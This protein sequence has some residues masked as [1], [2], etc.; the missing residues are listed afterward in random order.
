MKLEILFDDRDKLAIDR[1][2]ILNTWS[3]YITEQFKT[4]RPDDIELISLE[5]SPE[6]ITL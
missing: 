3:S 5:E 4:P 1:E 6:I 2:E